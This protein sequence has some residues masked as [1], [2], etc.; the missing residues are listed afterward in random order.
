MISYFSVALHHHSGGVVRFAAPRMRL[1]FCAPPSLARARTLRK[2]FRA[3]A[4]PP[5]AALL[6]MQIPVFVLDNNRFG[7]GR[8][9]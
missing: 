7:F 5:S 6:E 8:D 4:T 3:M 9:N 2:K 1:P